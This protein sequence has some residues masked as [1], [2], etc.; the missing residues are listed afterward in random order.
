MKRISI[1]VRIAICLA[2]LSLC[3]VLFARVAGIFPDTRKVRL[4]SRV[5]LCELLA[6]N[7]SMLANRGDIH[8]IERNLTAFTLR[9]DAVQSAALRRADGD[10]VVQVG[11]HGAHWRGTEDGHSTNTNIY[12]PIT[13]ENQRWGKVEVTFKPLGGGGLLRWVSPFVEFAVFTTVFNAILFVFWLRRVLMHLD[14]SR[15]MP[16]RVRAALDTLAEGLL[17]LDKGG[18]IMMANKAFEGTLAQT[19]EELQGRLATDLP[20]ASAD[21]EVAAPWSET[22]ASGSARVG[23]P[24]KLSAADDDGERT[25]MVNAAPILGE[26]GKSRGVLASFYDV[27]ELETK[28]TELLKI[29]RA[30]KTSREEIQ[31]Q[32]V[33]LKRL[34]TMDPLTEC[35]NRRSFFPQFDAE[36]QQAQD[37]NL[38]LSGFMVDIDHFKSI[39]DD[40]GHAKGDAVLRGVAAC[41]REQIGEDGLVCRFGGE[42]FCALLPGFTLEQGVEKAERVRT[43]LSEIDFEILSITASIGVSAINLGAANPQELLEQADKCL[44]VAKRGGRNKVVPYSLDMDSVQVDESKVRRTKDDVA[45]RPAE[46]QIPF[47]AVASLTSALAYRHAETAEHCSRVADLC[48]A[49]ARNVMTVSESYVLEIAA[50]L[51]DIGKI[52]VPDAILLKPGKLTDD[53]WQV[54]KMNERIGVEIVSSAFDHQGLVDIIHYHKA[55]FSQQATVT[56]M[57]HGDQLPIGARILAIADAYDAMVTQKNYRAALTQ[58]DALAELR[59]CAGVQFDPDLVQRFGEAVKSSPDLSRRTQQ[60]VSRQAAIRVATQIEELAKAL[61]EQ[62]LPAIEALSGRLQATAACSG[63][64]NVEQLAARIHENVANSDNVTELFDLTMELTDLCRAAQRAQFS[65]TPQLANV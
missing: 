25:F 50:L 28:K 37:A 49:V 35:L 4:Q 13:A 45:A 41:L 55:P 16:Q 14:P 48:V 23:V 38:P 26:D 7:C 64:A 8:G 15:V 27:T 34:A 57:P 31:E 52:G 36:W 10:V 19:S 2:L 18:R 1:S 30:L 20:W 32:N 56:H 12:V 51:H 65:P 3:G 29:L 53:E 59:R 17:V 58:D 61:D 39:N 44:Y 43:A 46:S 33:Q 22:L 63:A 9:N 54:M 62:D 24:M 5:A 60:Y 42:E 6:I 11:D 40:H 21:D 47:A